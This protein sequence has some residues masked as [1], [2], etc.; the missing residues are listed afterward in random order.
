[1]TCVD[2]TNYSYC[3]T[4]QLKQPLM[5]RVCESCGRLLRHRSRTYKGKKK[6]SGYLYGIAFIP[7]TIIVCSNLYN[8]GFI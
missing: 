2:Y 1:M 3:V 8:I 7:T 6:H 4:C 5:A